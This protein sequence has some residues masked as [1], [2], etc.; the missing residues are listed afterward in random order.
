M[1]HLKTGPLVRAT[2]TNAVV[3]WAELSAQCDVQV[4]IVPDAPST[5]AGINISTTT[6]RVGGHYYVALQVQE[7]QP[8]TWYTYSLSTPSGD[9]EITAKSSPPLIQCFRTFDATDSGQDDKRHSLRLAYGSCRKAEQDP[10][11]ALRALGVWLLQHYARRDE[12]WPH[13]LLCIGDQIYAD[14][15][16]IKVIQSYPHLREGAR[17]F[18]DFC[19]LYAHAWSDDPAVQQALAAIPSFM[20]FD[21][22]EITNNWNVEPTWLYKVIRQ[23]NE[24]LLID[25]LVAYWVYQGWGNLIQKAVMDHPL[26]TIMHDA[27]Q[28]GEDALEKLRDCIKADIYNNTSIRWHYTIETQ[29]SIF[30]ANA[31]TERT[32]I[33]D[34]KSDEIYGPL[35]IMS[36][37]QMQDIEQWLQLQK[38]SPSIFVSSVPILLPPLI[39]MLQYLS[40]ERLW[41]RA[42]YPLRQLGRQVAR[43]QRSVAARAGFDH[44]PLYITTWHEFLHLLRQKQ[45][46][47]IILSGDVHFS[48]SLVATSAANHRRLRK[49]EHQAHLYQFVSTPLQNVLGEASER[50][51]KIQAFITKI[52]YSGLHIHMLPLKVIEGTRIQ[53]NLV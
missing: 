5:S 36:Q 4:H 42:G 34:E 1:P 32:T 47:I 51:V 23:G 17:A 29:P 35:R 31:R 12:C 50:K 33:A 16:P 18:E 2:S 25:G 49:G 39:G 21:D 44:W 52:A 6:V 30:V 8:S 14:Q 13:L 22:H 43:L 3:I 40:G 27:T 19:I 7:L 10:S 37:K 24:Q 9:K 28:S 46:E 48:Y 41:A 15:P 26:I 45:Q 53:A 38:Q 11:D 20:I